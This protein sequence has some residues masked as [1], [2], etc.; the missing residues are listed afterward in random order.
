MTPRPTTPPGA[1]APALTSPVALHPERTDDPA[2]LRWQ[3]A[4]QQLDGLPPGRLHALVQDGVLT[5]FTVGRDHVTTTLAAG[6]TWPTVAPLV[7]AAVA[8]AVAEARQGPAPDTDGALTR[9][10]EHVLGLVAPYAAGHAGAITLRAVH[11]GVVEVE[12]GGACRGCPAASTT[13]QGRVARGLAGE[14]GF[15]EV[16]VAGES[17]ALNDG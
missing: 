9:A 1:P 15:V 12:L 16:R 5:G 13:L 7:R 17:R 14:P 3:V 6:H 10:A 4:G 11:G 8:G 2:S